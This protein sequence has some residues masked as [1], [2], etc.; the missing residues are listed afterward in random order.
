MHACDK[1]ELVTFNVP[2]CCTS[3]RFL[4]NSPAL[5]VHPNCGILHHGVNPL[6][7]KLRSPCI[8]TGIRKKLPSSYFNQGIV[9]IKTFDL[10]TINLE[11]RFSGEETNGFRGG[12][13]RGGYGSG[14]GRGVVPI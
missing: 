8:G 1:S 9:A 14:F 4:C 2:P 3:T 11:G 13:R 12:G 7:N 10:G 5:R 6:I